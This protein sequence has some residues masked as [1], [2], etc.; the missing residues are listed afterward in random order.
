MLGGAEEFLFGR[1]E[2]FQGGEAEKFLFGRPEGFQGGEAEEFFFGGRSGGLC[3]LGR[4]PL[5]FDFKRK[6]KVGR[7]FHLLAFGL[8]CLDVHFRHISEKNSYH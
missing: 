4:K 5:I 3:F 1:P 2:G 8:F 6:I 7:A